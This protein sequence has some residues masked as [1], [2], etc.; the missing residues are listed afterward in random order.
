[1][2]DILP[3]IKFAG[4]APIIKLSCGMGWRAIFI[5]I[6]RHFLETQFKLVSCTF[7]I[8]YYLEC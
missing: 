7:L 5:Y 8:T 2:F 1:M 4:S 6:Y 3:A